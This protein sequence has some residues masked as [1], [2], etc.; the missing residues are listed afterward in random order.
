MAAAPGQPHAAFDSILVTRSD[1]GWATITLNRP[2]RRNTLSIGLRKELA[3]AVQQL[4]ADGMSVADAVR[5][6][7]MQRLRTVLM[8]ALL[9]MLGLL[10]MALSQE[11][12]AETQ[13]LAIGT[14][15]GFF[16]GMHRDR[17]A[18]ALDLQIHDLGSAHAAVARNLAFGQ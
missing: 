11:I 2:E 8:T 18:L 14:L 4:Q 5:K 6:G 15:G 9:A 17:Y 16:Q 12:G 13:R 7:S 1:Q 3:A 10:P